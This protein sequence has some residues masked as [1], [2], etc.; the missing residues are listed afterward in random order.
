M[1]ALYARIDRDLVAGHPNEAVAALEGKQSSYGSRSQVLYSMDLGMLQQIAGQY[2][3]SNQSLTTAEDLSEALYTRRITSEAEAFLT[4]DTA[5]PYEG[6]DFEKV[7]LNI[8]MMI[9]YADLG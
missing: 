6:E 5:L 8:V 4:N 2:H 9:N 1:P 7:M 3:E